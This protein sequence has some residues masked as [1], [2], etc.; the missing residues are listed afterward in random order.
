MHCCLDIGAAGQNERS[1]LYDL[2]LGMS[3]LMYH[4]AVHPQTCVADGQHRALCPNSHRFDLKHFNLGADSGLPFFV[5]DLDTYGDA[6][7]WSREHQPNMPDL[8]TG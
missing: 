4:Y 7:E 1:S 6:D 5:S 2:L 3:S 8:T